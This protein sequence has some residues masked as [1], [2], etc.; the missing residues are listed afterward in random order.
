MR[1]FLNNDFYAY[2]SIG[3][4]PIKIL[5]DVPGMI[6]NRLLHALAREAFS[7]IEN[8]IA[9][10]EDIDNALKFGSAFR[11]AASG[12]LEVADIGGLDIWLTAGDNIFPHYQ[13]SE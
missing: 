5:K 1:C 9:T 3:K 4:K 12:M 6:A 8:G 2:V 13:I 11:A 7:L 10:A